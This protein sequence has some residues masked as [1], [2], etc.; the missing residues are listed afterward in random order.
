MTHEQKILNDELNDILN[1]FLSENNVNVLDSIII[2]S[3]VVKGNPKAIV[4]QQWWV[5]VQKK[6]L[7]CKE[8]IVNNIDNMYIDFSTLG[9]IPYQIHN[10]V[11][12]DQIKS[13]EHILIV[14]FFYDNIKSDLSNEW[15]VLFN[16]TLNNIDLL[17]W[18]IQVAGEYFSDSVILSGILKSKKYF[19]ITKKHNHYT[20]NL[21]S[22]LNL[23]NNETVTNGVRLV[24]DS[25]K[26]I[27]TVL[28]NT[29]N[30]NHLPSDN[31]NIGINFAPN[32]DSG[33]SLRRKN[34]EG[35][36]QD[37]N[38][39]AQDFEVNQLPNINLY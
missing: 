25:G 30:T 13:I 3:E 12:N 31:N 10:L 17:D 6:Y 11:N 32:A 23:Q 4:N 22:K 24:N 14:E 16:P 36:Y 39:S 9:N 5:N 26:V 35:I 8:N 21:I 33:H 18:K 34:I 37:N 15:L 7:S 28:Y 27:D 38:L 1:N 20:P 2:D 19:L 29:N